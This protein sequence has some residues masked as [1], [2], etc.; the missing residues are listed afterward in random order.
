MFSKEEEKFLK[1]LLSS[2]ADDDPVITSEEFTQ[3]YNQKLDQV[4]QSF[5]YPVADG[6]TDSDPK[7]H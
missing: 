7:I 4:A 6:K 3:I 1:D 5:G 2:D